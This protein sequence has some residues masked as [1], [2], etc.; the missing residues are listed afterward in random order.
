M[1]NYAISIYITT[2]LTIIA[3][4][5]AILLHYCACGTDADFWCNICLGIFGSGLLTVLVSCVGYASE[6]KKTMEGFYF[7][8][9]EILRRFGRYGLNWERGHK[10]DFLVDCS[11]TDRFSWD[12]YYGD[13]YFLFD[14]SRKRINYV[15][16]TIYS[17]IIR[18]YDEVES[19]VFHLKLYRDG[20][21]NN[22]LVIDKMIAEIESMLISETKHV[23]ERNGET[24]TVTSEKA[25]LTEPIYK[26]LDGKYYDLMYGKAY[27]RVKNG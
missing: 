11:E 26:E 5:V 21:S 6:K 12:A 8:T 27:R 9:N 25:I 24:F 17:P 1:R 15:F 13:M 23:I 3:L 14:F 10:I 7:G 4:G 22:G 2:P 18:F 16:E 20:E 19:K